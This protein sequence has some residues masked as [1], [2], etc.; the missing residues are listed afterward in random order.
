MPGIVSE[1]G[2]HAIETKKT[3]RLLFVVSRPSEARLIDPRSKPLTVL[4][5][6]QQDALGRIK[7]EFLRPASIENLQERSAVTQDRYCSC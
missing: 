4:S 3:C 7:V 5:A 1:Q 2:P 6:I